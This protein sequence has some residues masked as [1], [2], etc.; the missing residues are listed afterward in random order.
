MTDR[1]CSAERRKIQRRI[2]ENQRRNKREQKLSLY[3]A[4]ADDNDDGYDAIR[5]LSDV[6]SNLFGDEP[7]DY[8]V[9]LWVV[10]TMNEY[11]GIQRELSSTENEELHRAKKI[12]ERHLNWLAKVSAWEKARESKFK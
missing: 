12:Y 2:R 4:D 8:E 3:R 10:T 11:D 9:L 7:A 6:I 1:S 5:T